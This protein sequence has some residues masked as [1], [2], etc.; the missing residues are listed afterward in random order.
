MIKKITKTLLI[1][2]LILVLAILYL[3]I[4]GIKTDK[5]NNQITRNVLKI[6]KKINL[7]LNDVKYL[8]NPF[9]FT[10]DIKTKNPQISLAGS[11]L[12]IKNIQTNIALKP[13]ISNQFSISYLQ[14]NTKEIKLNDLIA[15]AR[16][17]ENSPKLFVLNTIIKDGFINANVS[18]HFGEKGKIKENYKIEGSIRGAKLNILNKLKLQNLNFNF[19]IDQNIYSLKRIEMKLNDIKITSPLIEIQEKKNLFSVNG[20]FLN[21]KKNFNIEELKLI[22]DN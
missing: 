9:N 3:S 22:F 20:Q 12:G 8:L 5:F 2:F 4:F 19:D 10:I 18:L 15:L 1:L 11:S 7:S 14:F 17:F 21:N 6:N 13:L 16:V